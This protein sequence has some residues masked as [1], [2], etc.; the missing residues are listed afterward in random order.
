MM[1]LSEWN[2][3]TAEGTLT[4]TLNDIYKQIYSIKTA[5]FTFEGTQATISDT[6]PVSGNGH[7]HPISEDAATW[8]NPG[9][10]ASVSTTYTPA[11]KIT[12][13]WGST[14]V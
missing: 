1:A 8:V 6:A 12:V 2:I 9:G 3:T 10:S 7:S 4:D 5:T 13:T 14:S 11:G